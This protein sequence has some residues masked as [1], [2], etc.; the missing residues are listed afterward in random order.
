MVVTLRTPCD[1]AELA[2]FADELVP[3]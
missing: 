2:N 1:P 3:P